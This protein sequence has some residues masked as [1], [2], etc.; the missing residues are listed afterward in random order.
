M[1][2]VST[3]LL[4]ALAFVLPLAAC[5]SSSKLPVVQEKGFCAV[6]EQVIQ[7]QAERDHVA[8]RL[9]GQLDPIQRTL[10]SRIVTN[11]TNYRVQCQNWDNPIGKPAGR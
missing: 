10:A 1:K 6:Y 5:S 2:L 8:N 7:T 11:E 9:R 4:L 3:F